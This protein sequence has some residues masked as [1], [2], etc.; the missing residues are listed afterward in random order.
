MR[1]AKQ[2]QGCPRKSR[3]V[4]TGL[5]NFEEAAM[6]RDCHGVS[7]VVRFQL[8]KDIADMTFRRIFGNIQAINHDFIRAALWL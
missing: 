3:G 1:E 2:V 8:V 4:G 5:L 7:S 6:E